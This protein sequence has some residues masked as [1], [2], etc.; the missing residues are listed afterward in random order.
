MNEDM[1]FTTAGEM[2]EEFTMFPEV[3]ENNAGDFFRFVPNPEDPNDPQYCME[4]L[5]V[6]KFH[7]TIFKYLQLQ[8]GKENEDE[9]MDINFT[10]DIKYV[11]E[12]F[13]IDKMT[14]DDKMYFEHLLSQ[15]LFWIFIQQSN[16]VI[17]NG[18]N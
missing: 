7:G 17:N 4:I 9:T 10:Y 14:E 16:K 6:P 11:P 15:I 3:D 12:D 13:D 18:Q 8:T 1:K 5:D 2:M